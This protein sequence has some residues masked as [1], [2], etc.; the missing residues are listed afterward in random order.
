MGGRGRL[1]D[2]WR[3]LSRGKHVASA[4][5]QI[6][7][8]VDARELGL[9]RARSFGHDEERTFRRVALDALLSLDDHEAR[10]VVVEGEQSV[11]GDPTEGALLVVAERAGALEAELPR[12]DTLPDL[13]RSASYMLTPGQPS[14]GIP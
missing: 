13:P 8:R 12:I 6:R 1:R 3:R 9:E 11:E 4:P 2:P 10:L 5:R 7:E 14:P